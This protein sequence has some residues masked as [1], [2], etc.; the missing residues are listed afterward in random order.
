MAIDSERLAE[1][2]EHADA[3][4]NH[5][6]EAQSGTVVFLDWFRLDRSIRTYHED[7]GTWP[8]HRGAQVYYEAVAAEQMIDY[9]VPLSQADKDMCRRICPDV[10]TE[11]LG[12]LHPTTPWYVRNFDAWV[13]D[14]S[15]FQHDSLLLVQM[16]ASQLAVATD[17][18]LHDAVELLA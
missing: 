6:E 1:V 14:S 18:W 9:A 15:R 17:V 13:T 2:Y 8:L 3:L 11:T 10:T 16:A 12:Y 5:I 7:T 4:G